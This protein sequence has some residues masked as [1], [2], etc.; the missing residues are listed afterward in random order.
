MFFG[1]LEKEPYRF[2]PENLSGYIDLKVRLENGKKIDITK[3]DIPEL[4]RNARVVERGTGVE[5]DKRIGEEFYKI[6]KDK[7]DNNE[8]FPADDCPGERIIL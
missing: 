6:L 4:I 7:I 2:D 5:V 8:A 1:G 3:K